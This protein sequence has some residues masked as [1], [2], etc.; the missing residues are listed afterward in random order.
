MISWGFIASLT[1]F[2]VVIGEIDYLLLSSLNDANLLSLLPTRVTLLLFALWD[3]NN[4][5]KES[6]YA[7]GGLKAL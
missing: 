5:I 2:K 6:V 3:G 7:I 4:L 1:I